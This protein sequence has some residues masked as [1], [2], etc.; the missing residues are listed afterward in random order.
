MAPSKTNTV[1]SGCLMLIINYMKSIT[2]Q[3]KVDAPMEIVWNTWVLPEEIR[4]WYHASDDWHAPYAENNLKVGGKFVTTMAAK[5]GSASFDFNGVY[6]EVIMHQKISYNIE[7]GR[8]VE[9]LFEQEA[10]G[11]LVLETFELEDIN[12]EE[13]QRTGW[14][15]I[16]DNFKKRV[17]EK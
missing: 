10:D 13:M 6:T 1:F 5:D 17:E 16:L 11:I 4:E 15:A 12:H 2:V 8:K 9:V 14:Q 7:G 3:T